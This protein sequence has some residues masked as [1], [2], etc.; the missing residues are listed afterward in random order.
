MSKPT[1]PPDARAP[2]RNRARR[3][4]LTAAVWLLVFL[5][6]VAAIGTA[7]ARYLARHIDD[8]RPA[9]ES[10]LSDRLGQQVTIGGLSASW[11]GPDPVLQANRLDIGHHSRDGSAVSLQHLLLR[12]D[13][14]RSLLRMG[15]VFERIEADG[16]DLVVE[17]KADGS[18]AVQGL[19]LPETGPG[20][21]ELEGMS[22]EQWLQP[23][24]WLN[25]LARRISDPEI[26]LTHLTLGL[27]TPDEPT[28]F[29]D[30]PQLDLAYDDERMSASGRAMRQGTLD[31]LATFSIEGTDLFDGRFSGR[32]WAEVT[33]GG[34]L[35]GITRGL[36]WRSFQLEELN[37]SATA[38]L[39]FADGQ[40]VRLNGRFD[41]PRLQLTNELANLPAVEAAS[42]RIGWRRTE[43]GGSLHLQDLAWRWRDYQV[44]GMAVK[45][46]HDRLQ[47]RVGATGV[48]LRPLLRMAV[49]S[50][51][52][53]AR[54][55]PEVAG[56]DP[57][58]RL[59]SVHLTL[60]RDHPK[61]FTM[62]AEL[63]GVSI[64]P[65]RGAPGG[66]NLQGKVWASR[67]GGRVRANGE[68][69]TMAIPNLY[70]Q[71]LTFAAASGEVGWRID[72]GVTR[73]FGRDLSARYGEDTRLDGAFDLKLD[74]YGD[75][76]LGL[77]IG[78]ANARASMLPAALPAKVL[79]QGLYD[80]LTTSITSGE[81]ISGTFYGHGQVGQA[82]SPEHFTTAMEFRFR[83]VN[84]SYDSSWPEV[85]GASGTV[86]IHNQNARVTLDQ[87]T[88]G[89][90]ELPGGQVEVAPSGEGDHT[91]SVSTRA[92]VT[93]EQVGYWLKETPLGQM[94]GQASRTVTVSGDYDIDLALAMP[95]S[96]PQALTV[97]AT[98]RTDNGGLSYLP[99]DLRWQT[100]QG[101]L[102][103]SSQD[104]FSEEAISAR[105]L[106]RPVNLRF[107]SDPSRGALT[108][109]QSGETDVGTLSD[110]L[111]P[112]GQELP[113][114]SGVL[115]YSARLD[116]VPGADA[117]L[118]VTAGDSGLR[119]QWPAPL[120]RTSGPGDNIE[121]LLRWP[122]N[123]QLLLEA[124]WGH[125]L[126][127]AL[128]WRN[129]TFRG[130][131]VVINDGSA[132]FPVEGG[133]MVRAAFE[134]LAPARWQSLLEKLGVSVGEPSSA[135]SGSTGSRFDWLNSID[136]RMD[137]LIVGD[138]TIPGVRVTAR[139]QPDGWLLETNSER[140]TGR[141]TIPD[142]GDRIWVDLDRLRLA[143]D[144]D[145]ATTAGD[146][147][148]L[149][150]PSEQLDAF[151]RMAAGQWP[152]VEVR[153]ES[154]VM[155]DDPAGSW[156]FVLSPSPEQVTLQ[157]LQGQLGTLAFDGQLRWG[158]TSGEQMTVV[159]GVLEGGGLQDLASLL[160]K[161]V[162][163]TNKSTMINLNIAWPGRPD[164]FA[165]G[166]LSGEFSVRFDDGVIL[167][168][169][170]TAQLFRLFNLLNT[171]TLQR[172][173]Q[174]DFSDLYEAGVAFDAIYG[175]ARLDNGILTWDP[176][177]QLA[178]PSGALRLSGLTNLADESLEMR[179]VVILPLTQNLPLAAILMG[180][181]PPVGGA[182]FVLDKLLGEPLSKLT[183]AT[184]SVRG[185]WD[186]PDVKLR[187]IFDSGN[188]E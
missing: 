129:N 170:E 91:V 53:P 99:A 32:V 157:D 127:A 131:Q 128:E 123:E 109:I 180:A 104:G 84:V 185:T 29:V 136:L 15:L 41:M 113:G 90:V 6:L 13:G 44:Q 139:P 67:H 11:Q 148:T 133:L 82:H 68:S 147:A 23:D 37:A 154:L 79:D 93:G 178:G 116:V 56:L 3:L 5:L 164:Q 158:V 77:R 69:M 22:G 172:R 49:V 94:T 125:R 42:A 146:G 182:L 95:V 83:D 61:D 28:L 12:L 174:F 33:P 54:V 21:T 39:T 114:L 38:W 111:L 58:G 40:L 138:H 66:S 175:K 7:W 4:L 166:R 144:D 89:G 25:E 1:S 188:R 160:G 27:K 45:L 76:N 100:I 186:N 159:Q 96:S 173:L 63:D 97:D 177:L 30:I 75:D 2:D 176:D 48:P 10:L 20:L 18:V 64:E 108:V 156:S 87:A 150:T 168:N 47:W 65:H 14:V 50:N 142:S 161:D 101:T 57:D 31:Q 134:R 140:A 19:T 62:L 143:R 126:S 46:D 112:R 118:A 165:A 110:A 163:L 73:V 124:S 121:V 137:E 86:H 119:S 51:L 78:V 167:E 102:S 92:T 141:V 74:R 106:G 88:T 43:A 85:V 52:L 72:G 8:Y 162:P 71:S 184:Y 153:I 145:A 35:E 152:E 171:D 122:D 98:L 26:R 187:N 132:R 105:F 117:R 81:V 16:L 130:G 169:N 17:R 179:L 24:R 181:S 151:Q 107:R 59:S 36:Q 183:S 55:E 120:G 70:D 135:S 155:K 34:V 9:I 80:W 60:P 103:Y 115:P 149:L